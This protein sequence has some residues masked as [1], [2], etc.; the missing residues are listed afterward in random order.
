MS[1]LQNQIVKTQNDSQF[2]KLQACPT[3]KN[4]KKTSFIPNTEISLDGKKAHTAVVIIEIENC[5]LLT[6]QDN[7]YEVTGCV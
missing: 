4:K 2:I 3:R 6:N 7:I 5:A 1:N